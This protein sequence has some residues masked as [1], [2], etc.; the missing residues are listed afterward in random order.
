MKRLSNIY[1]LAITQLILFTQCEEKQHLQI[2]DNKFLSA[3]I[4][5]GV[6][7]DEDGK[8]SLDEAE[9]VTN[10]KELGFAFNQLASVDLS[11]N[12]ELSYLNAGN[13]RLKALDISTNTNIVDLGLWQNPQLKQVCVWTT[14]F[15]KE[16][17]Q[18][19]IHNSPDIYFTTNCGNLEGFSGK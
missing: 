13:N 18:L 14:P 1:I 3:L 11:G 17:V 4:E 5:Q 6:D 16:G 10:L 19:E 15:P 7:L 9:A 12:P 2:R 8:I